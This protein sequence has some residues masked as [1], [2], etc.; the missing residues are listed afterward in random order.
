MSVLDH[1]RYMARKIATDTSGFAIPCVLKSL[2]GDYQV[3]LET[4][5]LGTVHFLGMDADGAPVA[6]KN[7]HVSFNEEVLVEGGYPV[8]NAKGEVA[9]KNH[10]VIFADSTGIEK[11][12]IIS[13]VM[14][15]R[16]LGH[17]V[18][19]LKDKLPSA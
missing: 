13:E 6:T 12:F 16:T 17:I 2:P 19:I 10:T 11:H 8:R 4:T 1:A 14:P 3:T 7:A 18:C 9:M 15:S 5:C